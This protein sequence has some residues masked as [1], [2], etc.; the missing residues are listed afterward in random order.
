VIAGDFVSWPTPLS[1]PEEK[2]ATASFSWWG[3]AE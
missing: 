2:I 1:S 3:Q